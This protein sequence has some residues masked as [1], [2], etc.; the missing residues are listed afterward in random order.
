ML[1][2][3]WRSCC[4]PRYVSVYPYISMRNFAPPHYTHPA[5]ALKNTPRAMRG[6][7]PRHTH[8]KRYTPKNSQHTIHSA[9]KARQ[10]QNRLIDF[11][12][13]LKLIAS[14]QPS[15]THAHCPLICLFAQPLTNFKQLEIVCI[16]QQQCTAA[17][18]SSN[19]Q[20]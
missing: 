6:Y 16:L 8:S 9:E 10:P 17:M 3:V 2:S 5:R 13:A 15:P 18:Q 12:A 1:P 4:I 19:A 14:F 7:S 20:Q 11:N